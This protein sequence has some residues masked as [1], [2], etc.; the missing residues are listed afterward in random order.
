M[1]LEI[2]AGTTK[3]AG[4]KSL[5]LNPNVGA[6]IVADA[7]ATGLAN[8]SI[9]EILTVHVIEHFWWTEIADVLRE[10]HRI[11]EPNGK[12][13]LHTPDL[14]GCVKGWQD[15]SWKNELSSPGYHFPKKTGTDRTEW[16]NHKLQG[17]EAI[18]NA[19][20]TNFNFEYLRDFLL[21]AGFKTVNHVPSG[22][23]FTLIVEAIK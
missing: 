12:L 20:N 14:D 1:K 4:Y 5:D 8:D 19:H 13:I 7:R 9:E 6:D 17:T 22:D 21:E 18:G 15:G 16:L 11:L 10:W 2:G 23:P 3:R